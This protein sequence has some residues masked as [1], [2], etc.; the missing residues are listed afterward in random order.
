MTGSS[1]RASIA[2][3]ARLERMFTGIV[4]ALGRVV[5]FERRRGGARIRIRPRAR[6]RWFTSGESVS[7]SGVCVTAVAPGSELVADLSGET[8]ARSTLGKSVSGSPVNLER[9]LRWGDPLSGHFVMGHVDGVARLLSVSPGGNAWNYR[10]SIPRGLARFVVEK[11]SVALDGVSLTVAQRRARDFTVAVIPE[12][13]RR[14]TLGGAAPGRHFNFEADVF[15]RYGQ[16]A[17]VRVRRA[18]RRSR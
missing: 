11:G 15:A 5:T 3:V 18:S 4:S 16:R 12:T 9:A 1:R 17:T 13:R 6:A 8:L 10:F 7:V 14:T 2:G